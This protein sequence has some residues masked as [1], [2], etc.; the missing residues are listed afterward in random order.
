LI[1]LCR[2][3]NGRTLVLFTSYNQHN[4]TARSIT[5][6]LA[7]ADISVFA[8][9]QGMSRRQLL[10]NFR[11]NARSVLRL[12]SAMAEDDRARPAKSVRNKANTHMVLFFIL[13]CIPPFFDSDIFVLGASHISGDI[14]EL[15]RLA[16]LRSAWNMKFI[17]E[18]SHPWDCSGGLA[19]IELY[20]LIFYRSILARSIRRNPDFRRKRLNFG[21]ESEKTEPLH[22]YGK[23]LESVIG[24]KGQRGDW[25]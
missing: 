19:Q 11:S 8:Q 1:Q 13:L 7:K 14:F 22:F 16:Y 2:S 23:E 9:G 21:K 6:P 20:F 15:K 25:A 3:T 18:S 24:G 17:H 12:L 10:E 5:R 4:S